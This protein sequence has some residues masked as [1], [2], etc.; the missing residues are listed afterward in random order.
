MLAKGKKGVF[1]NVIAHKKL[2]DTVEV[3]VLKIENFPK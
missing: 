2:W 1:G 3:W